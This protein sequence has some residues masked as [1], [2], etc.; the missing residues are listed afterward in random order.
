MTRQTGII[1]SP[2]E[3]KKLLVLTKINLNRDYANIKSFKSLVR[4]SAA[5]RATDWIEIIIMEVLESKISSI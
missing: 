2:E 3:R 4:G 1:N 5:H